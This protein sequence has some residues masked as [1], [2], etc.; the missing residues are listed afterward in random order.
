MKQSAAMRLFA[1]ALRFS[2]KLLR[3]R[4]WQ[5]PCSWLWLLSCTG[6]IGSVEFADSLSVKMIDTKT[7]Y[8]V[9]PLSFYIKKSVWKKHS[10][11]WCW[12]FLGCTE[13]ANNCRERERNQ[14]VANVF[15][16]HLD[17]GTLP[18]LTCMGNPACLSLPLCPRY[19]EIS[20]AEWFCHFPNAPE[21]VALRFSP[22]R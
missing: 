15:T 6:S 22:G 16:K 21:L 12:G 9:E 10:Y 13:G 1:M 2:R 17:F 4:S 8:L 18:T 14:W 19:V 3:S 20:S 7:T 11:P 5:S